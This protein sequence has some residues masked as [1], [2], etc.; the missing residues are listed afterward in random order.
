M[1]NFDLSFCNS[2]SATYNLIPPSH[3][4]EDN[5]IFNI[6]CVTQKLQCPDIKPGKSPQFTVKRTI[7]TPLVNLLALGFIA[8]GAAYNSHAASLPLWEVGA[9]AGI[10][11]I[12]DYRGS[13]QRNTY[14]LPLPYLIYRGE[15]FIVDRQRV[16]G[17]LFKSDSI[18]MDIS[19]N[20]SVPVDSDD[21]PA[22]SGMP[23]LDPTV[24]IGPSLEMLLHANPANNVK[25]S[26]HLPVRKVLA[27]DFSHINSAGWVVNP[28]INLERRNFS[29]WNLGLSAGP[30]FATRQNHAYF[31]DVSAAHATPE[32]PAY[33][34][35]GGYS[36]M[37]ATLT[38]SRRFDKLWVGAFLRA[39][40]LGG[41]RFVDSPL[42]TTR[43]HVMAGIGVA[44]VFAQSR[45]LVEAEE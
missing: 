35:S 24:E 34:A 40:Y 1:P 39:D 13:D 33:S 3:E 38:A 30:L 45:K 7:N 4:S 44:W 25:V 2:P 28:K 21:N 8:L 15:T 11:S 20:A 31:Y 23:D 14:V 42:V 22:R 6:C 19:L 16:R 12:P 36:G 10:V 32:R 18:N 26:F 29:G 43:S 17:M 41:A 37:Q 27:T 5:V 9:G